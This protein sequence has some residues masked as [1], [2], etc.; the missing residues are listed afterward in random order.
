MPDL[1]NYPPVGFYFKVNIGTLTGNGEGNFQEVSG[2]NFK[3]GVK[4][5]PEGGE[6]RFIHKFPVPAKY[7]N[8]VLKRGMLIGSPL[9]TWAQTS[10]GQFT[11]KP[12]TVVI[13]LMDETSAPIATWKLINAIPVGLSVSA[14][15]AQ[16]NA[17][18][19]ETLEL[20]FDYFDKVK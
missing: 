5:V 19:V 11:F 10:V 12:V 1:L 16:E 7:E 17:I 3:F 4:E 2:L 6:N 8:L 15:K 18:A 14:F 9:I 13:N 20:S